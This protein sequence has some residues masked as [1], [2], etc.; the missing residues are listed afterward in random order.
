MIQLELENASKN[1]FN[2][3][4]FKIFNDNCLITN[5]FA[6]SEDPVANQ[7]HYIKEVELFDESLDST[8]IKVIG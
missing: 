7:F 5:M 8:K 6:H 3:D 4:K 2:F 1:S